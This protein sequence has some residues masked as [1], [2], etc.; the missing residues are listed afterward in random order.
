[1][2]VLK[3]RKNNFYNLI[4][5]NNEIKNCLKC[6]LGKSRNNFVF[7]VGDFNASLL[8]VGEAPGE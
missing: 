2:I 7:G 4:S 8:L 6:D 5:F 3:K 1:M